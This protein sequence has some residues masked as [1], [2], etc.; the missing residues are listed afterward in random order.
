MWLLLTQPNSNLLSNLLFLWGLVM[1]VPVLQLP[2]FETRGP[3]FTFTPPFPTFNYL[4]SP[5]IQCLFL[6]ISFANTLDQSTVNSHLDFLKYLN[7]HPASRSNECL[8]S[9]IPT[10]TPFTNIYAFLK[11]HSFLR[12]PARLNSGLVYATSYS[13]ST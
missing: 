5:L 9:T 3:F 8:S 7:Y 4:L 10:Q 12:I 6:S 1:V 13:L 11:C 2:T